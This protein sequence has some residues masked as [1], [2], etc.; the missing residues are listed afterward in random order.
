MS[1]DANPLHLYL[2]CND[3]FDGTP[4]AK[5]RWSSVRVAVTLT[6]EGVKIDMQYNSRSGPGRT[7]HEASYLNLLSRHIW[8]NR[9]R[10]QLLGLPAQLKPSCLK[11][12]SH[13]CKIENHDDN[14]WQC[15][16]VSA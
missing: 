4:A 8:A 12:D 9:V 6:V 15:C 7:R 10:Q 16:G 14:L 1:G 11:N 2:A 5:H 13:A 3:I